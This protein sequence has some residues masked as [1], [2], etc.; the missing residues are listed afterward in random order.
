MLAPPQTT[1]ALPEIIE[2]LT[3]RAGFNT[4]TVTLG[5]TLLGLAAGVVGVFAMLRNRAMTADAISHATLP[6]VAIAFLAAPALG[7]SGRSLPV[8]L[9]G[10]AISSAIGVLAI[11]AILRST[12]LR[13]DAAIG[14]VLSVFFGAGVVGLTYIQ[15]N[16]PEGSAGLT[17]ILLGQ[18]ATMRPPDVA[19]IAVIAACAVLATT[20]LFK[21]LAAVCFNDAFAGVQ[22]WPVA[23]IDLGILALVVLVTLAGLHAV[24]LVLIIALLIIP[25]AAARFWTERL[26]SLVI[27]AGA[28]GAVSGYIGCAISAL[29][30]DKPTGAIIVLVSGV[31]FV[32]SL[33]AAPSRGIAAASIRR[34]R[35]RLRFAADH[36]LESAYE[37]SQGV[38]LPETRR[39]VSRQRGWSRPFTLVILAILRISGLARRGDPGRLVLTEAGL[40]RGRRISRNHAL[41][42]EYLVSHADIA[43]S[44][45]DWSVDQVEHVLP[46]ELVERLE[47]RLSRRRAEHPRVPI[48]ET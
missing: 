30:P 22:G 28:L 24:G 3:L 47:A 31:L 41:W 2:V 29:L 25:P 42:E 26:G 23:A 19:F 5:T 12:R 6:G 27:I 46:P 1:P 9:T 45:V 33:I 39:A 20:L 17:A 44:H 13:E 35:Q 11:H 8:M 48:A 40:E 4:A 43:P 21:E 15:R 36:L 10:A 18:A 14:I 34:A 37:S 16:A 7:L 38:L 32:V